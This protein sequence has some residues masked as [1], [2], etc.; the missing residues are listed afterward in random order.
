[1]KKTFN[2]NPNST[3]PTGISG[4][5]SP[6]FSYERAQEMRRKGGRTRG[7]ARGFALMGTEQRREIARMGAYASRRK[8][9]PKDPFDVAI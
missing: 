6:N 5:A 9:I 2:K 4:F 8:K 7:I 3:H 1:M